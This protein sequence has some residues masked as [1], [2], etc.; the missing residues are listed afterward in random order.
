MYYSVFVT[1]T[2][3]YPLP[4]LQTSSTKIMIGF[5][6]TTRFLI[7]LDSSTDPTEALVVIKKVPGDRKFLI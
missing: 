4:G 6:K 3:W 2:T 5:I 7:L 1:S